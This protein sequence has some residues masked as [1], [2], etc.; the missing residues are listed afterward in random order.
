MRRSNRFTPSPRAPPGTSLF[1]G[2][3]GL[4]WLYF[5]PCP[6]LIN[7]FNYFIFQCPAPFSLHFPE[8]RPFLSHTFFLWPRGCRGGIGA[9]QFDRR[10]I[11]NCPRLLIRYVNHGLKYDETDSSSLSFPRINFHGGF[12]I[13]FLFPQLFGIKQ[14]LCATSY[15][16]TRFIFIRTFQ[17]N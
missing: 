10:I 1:F 14:K 16:D 8:S 5:L 3:P 4:F 12:L 7:H 2:C 17:R 6:A 13:E 15:H 9:E 11:P